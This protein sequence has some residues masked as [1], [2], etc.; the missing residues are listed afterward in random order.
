MELRTD[1]W[2]AA[3]L[4]RALSSGAAAVIA[5]KGDAQAGAVLVKVS[6]LNGMARL[7][8]PARDGAGEKIWLDLS[9]SPSGD[10]EAQI[11]ALCARRAAND[12]D[13]WIVDIEDRD[14]RNF[15]TEPVAR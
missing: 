12:P 5:R 1:I 11:E 13:L 9:S 7:Y 8:V 3:L 6:T 15:L 4:R 14:G 10:P 2:A